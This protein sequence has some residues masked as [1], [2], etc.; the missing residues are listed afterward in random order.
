MPF[1]CLEVISYDQVTPVDID[2]DNGD[3]FDERFRRDGEGACG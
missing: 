2:N 1:W 3:D